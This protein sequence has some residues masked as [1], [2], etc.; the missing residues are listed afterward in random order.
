M[1]KIPKETNYLV[2]RNSY[3]WKA[4]VDEKEEILFRAL[5]HSETISVKE[6]YGETCDLTLLTLASICHGGEC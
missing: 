4:R 2:S 6:M 3:Y 1:Y 5:P